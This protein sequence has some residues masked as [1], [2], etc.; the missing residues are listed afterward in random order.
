MFREMVVRSLRDDP[1]LE[2]VIFANKGH[3]LE[4]D[5]PRIRVVSFVTCQWHVGLRLLCDHVLVG[6]MA[7]MLGCEKI[8]SVGFVPT[9]CPLP[10]VMHM[11]TLHH[12]NAH[13]KVSRLRSSYRRV[14]VGNGL[15]KADLVITNS[16]F[17][18]SQIR[19]ST[20]SK[21]RI[22]VSNEGL[23]HEQFHPR[24]RP[25]E[26]AVLESKYALKPGYLLWLSNMYIYKQAESL[27]EKYALLP[28]EV[29]A[30][31]PLVFVGGDWV[32]QRAKCERLAQ[33]LGIG[34][35]VRFLGF[36]PDELIPALYRQAAAHVLASREETWGR[37]VSEAMACG[38]PCI[39][40]DIPVMH[41]VAR[42]AALMVNFDDSAK[43]VSGLREILT[44]EGTRER[45][46]E[47]GLARAAEL[48]FE[49][50]T[51]ERMAAIAESF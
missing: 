46:R 50:L 18:A 24:P 35:D 47:A 30:V 33:E 40:N 36:L 51:K 8:L 37:T 11:F 12:L 45:L 14:A 15:R 27:I 41:E 3:G 6:P 4:V 2:W 9:V 48:S 21:P 23:D 34:K 44:D 13:N 39:V 20:S 5:S 49:R 43:V 22:V 1:N 26:A 42:G 25:T 28:S 32:G 38:C 17:A 31:H 10:C 29:R 7:R 19:A 16:E